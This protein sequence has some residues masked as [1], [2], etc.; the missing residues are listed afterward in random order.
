MH[1][2]LQIPST[3][4]QRSLLTA[5]FLYLAPP[6]SERSSSHGAPKL[7]SQLDHPH[8]VNRSRLPYSPH[9]L[10]LH[11]YTF[12]LG[13]IYTGTLVFSHRTY[14]LETTFAILRSANYPSLPRLYNETQTRI[15][16]EMLHRLYHPFL[17]Y[18]EYERIMKVPCYGNR[19]DHASKTSTNNRRRRTRESPRAS[20]TTRRTHKPTERTS[21]RRTRGGEEVGSELRRDTYQR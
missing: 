9:H 21:E 10:L 3:P 13:Y 16:Y 18:D 2:R 8:W 11:L 17:E 6:T 7:P 4:P 20:T 14:D 1:S 5:S 15:V 12:T 19:C